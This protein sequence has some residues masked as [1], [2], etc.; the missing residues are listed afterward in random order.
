MKSLIGSAAGLVALAGAQAADLPWRVFAAKIR[1]VRAVFGSS[2]GELGRRAGLTQR[3]IHKLEQGETQPRGDTERALEEVWRDQLE[4][5][6][7]PDAG[8]RRPRGGELN[9]GN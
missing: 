5:E 3:A 8:L 9:M 7:L 4:F 2:Q 1:L 6:E